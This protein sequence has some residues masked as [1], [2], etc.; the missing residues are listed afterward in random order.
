[1]LLP[2]YPIRIEDSLEKKLFRTRIL[3]IGD[4]IFR[5]MPMN[6]YTLRSLNNVDILSESR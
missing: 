1:M 5:F 2:I 6:K 3:I 4:S